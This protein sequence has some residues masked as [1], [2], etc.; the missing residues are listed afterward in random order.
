MITFDKKAAPSGAAFARFF[1]DCFVLQEPAKHHNDGVVVVKEAKHKTAVEE[2]GQSRGRNQR[3]NRQD[4]TD[5]KHTFNQTDQR[6]KQV[7]DFA[8]EVDFVRQKIEHFFQKHNQDFQYNKQYDTRNQ[9]TKKFRN[10]AAS[11]HTKRSAS[12]KLD[13]DVFFGYQ[14]HDDCRKFSRRQLFRKIRLGERAGQIHVKTLY[15]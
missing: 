4:D 13:T 5:D 9:R 15:L 10:R 8:Q 3:Q 12:W 1:D 14:G 11:Q 6:T 2:V 7:I